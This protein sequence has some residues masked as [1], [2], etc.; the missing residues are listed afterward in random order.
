M[1]MKAVNDQVIIDFRAGG[2]ISI[3]GMHRERLVLL[4]TTGEESFQ[5]TTVPV[6]FTPTDAGILVVASNDGAHEAPHWFRNIVA[7]PVVHVE[8]PTREYDGAARVLAEKARGLA[9]QKLIADYPF[10]VDQQEGAGR[11]LP[12]VEITKTP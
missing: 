2:E 7:D 4:T 11:D 12:L 5:P 1:D 8:E 10:F 3:D 9:W 6:M